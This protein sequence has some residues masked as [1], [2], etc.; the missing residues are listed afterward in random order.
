[1][2]FTLCRYIEVFRS[3]LYAMN[4]WVGIASQSQSTRGRGRPSRPVSSASSRGRPIHS[5][6]EHGHTDGASGSLRG[7][8]RGRG[9]SQ[10]R[11][12]G[13]DQGYRGRGRGRGIA[14]GHRG[15]GRGRGTGQSRRQGQDSD[16][17]ARLADVGAISGHA[18]SN[19]VSYVSQT[20]FCVRMRG[21]PF[22]A[23][24]QDILD[25]SKL[26]N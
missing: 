26:L 2:C 19:S 10:G 16:S 12:R 1:M 7:N 24:E 25:V 14:Q 9:V 21:L 11:G 4:R 22:S 18:A 23:S 17:S 15:R 6:D 5:S 13:T 3:S 20:G 8:I